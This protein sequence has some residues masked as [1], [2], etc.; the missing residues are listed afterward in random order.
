MPREGAPG[1]RDPR[2]VARANNRR[3]TY[4]GI[5]RQARHSTRR[6]RH[7]LRY[8]RQYSAHR[9]FRYLLRDYSG[10]LPLARL[11]EAN[12]SDC[13]HSLDAGAG[14]VI[15][16]MVESANQL[17]EIIEHCAWPPT[18]QRGVGFS[19]GNL[20]GKYFEQYNKEAQSPIVIA[21]IEN[22]RAVENLENILK[23]PGLDAILIGPY[24]LSASMGLTGQ[25]EVLEYMDIL[26][27]IKKLS[28][29]FNIPYG[30]HVIHPD[31]IELQ[32]KI[33]DGYQFIAYSI[34]SVFLYRG[35]E[36][37]TYK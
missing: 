15:V 29:K 18:G 19:R 21:Q 8:L 17:K 25:F 31:S 1:R 23:V 2:K 5:R 28:K 24:D 11:S 9:R 12:A 20:F 30:I 13:K 35:A 36:C 22:I 32:A 14:G 34:D 16:P 27:N 3:E 10:T 6:L 37:P 26:S 7:S 4:R 33:A